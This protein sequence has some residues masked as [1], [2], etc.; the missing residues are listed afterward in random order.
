MTTKWKTTMD[1]LHVFLS[2][3]ADV[4]R[5]RQLTREV[6]GSLQKL[7]ERDFLHQ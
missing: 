4:S 1:Q 2:S 3:P 6:I 7:P 5:E